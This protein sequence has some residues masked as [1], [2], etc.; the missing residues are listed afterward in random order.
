MNFSNK[1]AVKYE[2]QSGGPSW[3]VL[4]GRRDGLVANQSGANTNLPGPTESVANIATKF[5][6]VGL[7]LTDVVS[8]S[9][10]IFHHR[11]DPKRFTS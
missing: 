7:N 5:L 3:K 8:L 2:L 6:A 11:Q 10:A 4:L 9:G 1:I